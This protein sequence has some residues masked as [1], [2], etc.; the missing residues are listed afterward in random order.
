MCYVCVCPYVCVRTRP[1]YRLKLL[2]YYSWKTFVFVSQFHLCCLQNSDICIQEYN[3]L[4]KTPPTHRASLLKFNQ[5]IT[6]PHNNQNISTISKPTDQK[7]P[8]ARPYRVVSSPSLREWVQCES[9]AM[10]VQWWAAMAWPGGTPDSGDLPLRPVASEDTLLSAGPPT[11]EA[12]TP[13]K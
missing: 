3:W 9:P 8:S 4:S 6:K 1:K 7:W 5:Q 12:N 11:D 13:S 10:V 2:F